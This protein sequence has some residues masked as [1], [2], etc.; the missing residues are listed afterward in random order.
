MGMGVGSRP[1]IGQEERDSGW[2]DLCESDPEGV[3]G[4]LVRGGWVRGRGE[5]RDV[6]KSIHCVELE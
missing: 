5:L 2:R 1:A 4:A 3:V 6:R